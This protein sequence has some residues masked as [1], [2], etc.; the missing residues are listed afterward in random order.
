M[1]LSLLCGALW[2]WSASGR[3]VQ[4]LYFMLVAGEF[5]LPEV[6]YVRTISNQTAYS[7]TVVGMAQQQ[8]QCNLKASDRK[9]L[10]TVGE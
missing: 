10:C 1:L 9:R 7:R 4:W 6:T 8:E 5:W 3:E 2:P